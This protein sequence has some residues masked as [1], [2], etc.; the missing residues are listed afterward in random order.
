[1]KSGT[2]TNE[3]EIKRE[4]IVNKLKEFNKFA[5]ELFNLSFVKKLHGSG[6][7]MSWKS[8]TGF[9]AEFRGP[10]DEAI[11]A[12]VNDIRRFY[13]KKGDTLRINTLISV[14]KSDLI[15]ESESKNFN[16][17]MS[18]LGEFKK[19]TTNNIINGENLTNE[20]IAEVFLYGRISHR[21]KGTKDVYDKWEK[22]PLLNVALKNQFITIMHTYL[23]IVD[24]IIYTNNQ[25]LQKLDSNEQKPRVLI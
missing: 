20:R 19:K 22:I 15:E 23:E 9:E 14:Y 5:E 6:Y 24:Y 11:K 1:M 13:Q 21:T 17:I 7:N 12:F 3:P 25:V 8:E 2:T 4:E 10:D 18:K 16:E